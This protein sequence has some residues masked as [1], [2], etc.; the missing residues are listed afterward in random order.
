MPAMICE[1]VP[2]PLSSS[3]LP[4]SSL[5]PG[6]TPLYLPPEA[7]PLPGDGGRHVGAVAVLVDGVGGAR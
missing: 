2:E 4:M 3:T 5:A 1:S 6:A 7:A